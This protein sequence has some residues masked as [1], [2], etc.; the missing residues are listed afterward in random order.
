MVVL[1]SNGDGVLMGR[2]GE[3]RGETKPSRWAWWR[4]WGWTFP[5]ALTL[6]G[7]AGFLVTV[8][9]TA[10]GT[11]PVLKVDAARTT[12]TILIG[13]G[14]A[15]TLVVMIHRQLLAVAE[16]KRQLADQAKR[17]EIAEHNRLDAERRFEHS[18][19]VA[20][21]NLA[22]ARA[23]AAATQTDAIEKRAQELFSKSIDQLG[24]DKA[25]VRVGA[26]HALDDLGQGHP[27]RRRA[28][29]D[30][31]C[32][33]L[34]MPPPP[35]PEQ[36]KEPVK[37]ELAQDA[38]PEP[39]VVWPAEELQV[40]AT[41]QRLIAEHL[42]DERTADS[43]EPVSERFWGPM[44]IDLSSAHLHS[45]DM[46][47]CQ[48]GTVTFEEATFTGATRFDEA[49]FRGECN[50]EKARFRG[51][52]GFSKTL[53]SASARFDYAIFTGASWF[54]EA[55]FASGAS[56][57]DVAFHEDTQFEWAT[58]AYASFTR[59][60]F[61]GDAAFGRASF[62]GNSIFTEATFTGTARFRYAIFNGST[63]FSK[64]VFTQRALFDDAAF[65]ETA[66]F[67]EA[68]F[69]DDAIFT[70]ASFR[71]YTVF[72]EA[73]FHK[74]AWYPSVTFQKEVKF[75]NAIFMKDINFDEA[76]FQHPELVDLWEARARNPHGRSR[77]PPGWRL[78]T[79]NDGENKR[80]ERIPDAP[81]GE[82][83]ETVTP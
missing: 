71:G 54:K 35:S 28:V 7:G 69:T 40:R 83:D 78:S 32:A 80:L 29:L 68:T 27:K 52:V 25:A 79:G 6:A 38:K 10:A 5:A 75:G 81:D 66:G 72:R 61:R 34:R 48:V 59:A 51:H 41:A 15:V 57:G 76:A 42:R 33:Y 47:R 23:V 63:H 16:H 21:D 19:R 14:G 82:A 20:A 49:V 58:F 43:T 8:V 13:L 62:R 67:D 17:F 36:P 31:W 60:A 3:N 18:E 55:T 53:F 11:D 50:F 26:L 4:R 1:A 56:F 44:G 73:I 30:V 22:H 70:E 24:S 12:F 2:E 9:W 45:L 74:D 65:H 64:A 77:L 46:S 39:V 37:A